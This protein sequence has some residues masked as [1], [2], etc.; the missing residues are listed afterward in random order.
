MLLEY[1]GFPFGFVLI[2]NVTD[3]DD[4][5]AQE[6]LTQGSSREGTKYGM[7]RDRASVPVPSH[8]DKV[9]KT[10]FPSLPLGSS[11]TN[12]TPVQIEN[13]V[14][15]NHSNVSLELSRKRG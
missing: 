4:L 11:Q 7:E 15:F 2:G 9:L 5:R 6:T 13:S 14:G 10:K 8:S 1:F 12:P 3:K